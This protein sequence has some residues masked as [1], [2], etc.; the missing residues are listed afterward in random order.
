M[1]HGGARDERKERQWQR[2]IGEWRASG[3]S[4]RAFCARHGLVAP[5]LAAEG[6]TRGTSGQEMATQLYPSPSR[7]CASRS[8]FSASGRTLAAPLRSRASSWPGS[9]ANRW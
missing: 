9:A 6:Q 5:I 7:S 4:A 1:A 8:V 2:L 3:L